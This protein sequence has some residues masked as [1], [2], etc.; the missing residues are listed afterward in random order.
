[1]RHSQ[2]QRALSAELDGTPLSGEATRHL[3]TCA[4]CPVFRTQLTALRMTVDRLPLG[5]PPNVVDRVLAQL[6]RTTPRRPTRWLSPVFGAAAGVLVGVILFG[7]P[8]APDLSVAGRLPEEVVTRQALLGRLSATF[9]VSERIGRGVERTYRG[10]VHYESPEYLALRVSQVAGPTGWVENNWALLIDETSAWVSEPFPCPELGGCAG[11]L[12]RSVRVVGRD[13]FSATVVAPLDVVIPTAVLKG[14][15]DP[16]PLSERTIAG[17]VA[18]GFE[19]SAAQAR[20][21]LDAYLGTGNWREVNDTDLVSIWLDAEYLTPLMIQVTAASSPER[22]E[23][24][25]RRGYADSAEP[26]LE[27]EYQSVSF[28]L[29]ERPIVRVP[30]NSAVRDSGFEST[31]SPAPISLEM[32]LVSSGR[33][34]GFVETEVWAWSDGRAFMRLDRTME[35]RGPGLFGNPGLP[36][37][38]TT[39]DGGVAYLAGDGSR[40]FIHGDDYD[41]V[42]IGSVA[43][44]QLLAAASMLPGPHLQVPADWPEASQEIRPTIYLPSDVAGF[45]DPIIHSINDVTVIDLFGGGQRWVR[46]TQQTGE[47]ISPPLDPDARAV[48]LRGLTGRY[49]P[50][51]GALEWSEQGVLFTIE[52]QGLSLTEI[53]GISE[54]L[55]RS[56]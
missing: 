15:G 10:D 54:T 17:R 48:Q 33:V 43:S 9:Q 41:A 19:V 30:A 2:V 3:E 18:V 22:A 53:I 5:S 52:G 34:Q 36:V 11:A 44:E 27:V 14:A 39:T 32:A 16:L 23:W 46:I 35:W 49:S 20:P 28:G 1:M 37:K 31:I 12:G 51:F 13:P 55:A 45:D 6:P 21:L 4:E 24:A 47:R 25:A 40:V 50:A 38:A 7:G 26:F 8:F 56:Q 29:V 42:L